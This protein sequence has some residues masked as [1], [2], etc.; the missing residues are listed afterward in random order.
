MIEINPDQCIKCL[1]CVS[2][3]PAMAIDIDSFIVKPNCIK[4]GHCV[5]ICPKQAIRF[6]GRKPKI[7]KKNTVNTQELLNL[8]K[9]NR[10]VRNY[11]DK[12]VPESKLQ[13]LLDAVKYY[14]SASNKRNV[15]ITVIAEKEKVSRLNEVVSEE[16]ISYFSKLSKGFG[17]FAVRMFAGKR[18]SKTVKKYREY[19]LLKRK[20]R[21][22]FICYSAPAIMIFHSKKSRVSMSKA[23]SYIWAVNTSHLA[24]AMG[25]SCCLV[26]YIEMTLN[27]SAAKLK[28]EFGIPAENEV[29]ATL[30][31]GYSNVNY[32]NEIDR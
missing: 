23:D 32:K 13:K 6:E 11:K 28:E 22:D 8:Y 5:A 2:E 7:L 26:G 15:N 3:C 19:F 27:R 30:L 31:I 24:Q 16:M 18:L 12:P 4:C 20:Q 9:N 1:K 21:N 17:N 10:S 14:P 29:H 25:L